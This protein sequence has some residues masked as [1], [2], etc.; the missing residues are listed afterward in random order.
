MCYLWR[1]P[2]QPDNLTIL[3]LATRRQ[4]ELSLGGGPSQ[5]IW[6]ADS[7]WNAAAVTS[8]SSSHSN[9]SL[10]AMPSGHVSWLDS[11]SVFDD[12]KFDWS[13]ESR[14]LAIVRQMVMDAG[15]HWGT[16]SVLWIYS[17]GGHRGCLVPMPPGFVLGESRWIT[18]SALQLR[19]R[20]PEGRLRP[21]KTPASS[22]Y[23]RAHD[24]GRGG[25]AGARTRLRAASWQV[26]RFVVRTAGKCPL[27]I[28]PVCPNEADD[29][30]WFLPGHWDVP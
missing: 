21:W 12:Y 11:L 15:N 20:T 14:H 25:T 22:S 16:A 5:S 23:R 24:R 2:K 4:I 17:A 3:D 19:R 30:H 27:T 1:P 7:R 29:V 8:Q 18:D 28:G 26:R 9:L 10:I 13:P 6:S